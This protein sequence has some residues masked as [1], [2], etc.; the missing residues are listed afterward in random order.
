MKAQE[1]ILAM[2]KSGLTLHGLIASLKAR[3][4][5]HKLIAESK[6]SSVALRQEARAEQAAF[7]QALKDLKALS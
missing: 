7:E 5:Y 2:V 3:R 1:E 4:D 6:H